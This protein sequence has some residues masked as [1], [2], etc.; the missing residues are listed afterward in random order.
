MLKLKFPKSSL[1][2]GVHCDNER[3][4]SI[5]R[6]VLPRSPSAGPRHKS[7]NNAAGKCVDREGLDC[8]SSD[9]DVAFNAEPLR[10]SISGAPRKEV[11]RLR[12]SH[13]PTKNIVARPTMLTATCMPSPAPNVR[14]VSRPKSARM[15]PVVNTSSEWRPQA[16]R[17]RS[18]EFAARVRSLG[19]LSTK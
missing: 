17:S 6:M 7:S 1:F 15:Q 19:E 16:S 10:A 18:D 12:S 14:N 13:S 8:G 5:R 9:D 4:G 11:S 3:N 2:F